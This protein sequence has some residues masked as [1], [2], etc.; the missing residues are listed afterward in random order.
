MNH[1]I[2]LEQAPPRSWEQFEELCADVFHAEWQD[3]SLMRQRESDVLLERLR[4]LEEKQLSQ[5]P[6][7]KRIELRKKLR[8]LE[9]EE[10]FSARG[11][12][13]ML[14]DPDLSPY[15]L[16]IWENAA[17]L[18]VERFM[19]AQVANSISQDYEPK[20][21]LRCI[22]RTNR[23]NGYPLHS[24]RKIFRQSY[25]EKTLSWLCTAGRS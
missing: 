23:K 13:L 19:N 18:A 7:T 10:Q 11:L 2:H 14:T 24:A 22:I 3:P 25:S 6:R 8:R 1:H 16:D 15:I 12:K 20:N 5:A 21:H 9:R 17:H 4:K